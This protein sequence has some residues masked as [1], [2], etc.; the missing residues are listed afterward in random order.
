MDKE[1]LEGK[2]KGF[3]DMISRVASSCKGNETT[4]KALLIEP[5]LQ[6]IGIPTMNPTY[7]HRENATI[8]NERCDYA[9]LREEGN[10]PII[11]I[12]AKAIDNRLTSEKELNQLDRYFRDKNA[13]LGALTNGRVW[14][15]YKA[16]SGQRINALDREPVIEFNCEDLSTIPWDFLEGLHF[17]KLDPENIERLAYQ[18]LLKKKLSSWIS[19]VKKNP[20]ENFVQLVVEESGLDKKELSQFVEIEEIKSSI[21]KL[22]NRDSQFKEEITTPKPEIKPKGTFTDGSFSEPKFLQSTRGGYK[23]WISKKDIGE[24]NLRS[25]YFYGLK[26]LCQNHKSGELE[27]LEIATKKF[28]R[29]INSEMVSN[30]KYWTSFY[31]N[32]EKTYFIYFHMGLLDCVRNLENFTSITVLHDG[33]MAQYGKDLRIEKLKP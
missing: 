2:L 20:S 32:G 11:L 18:E 14:K 31:K 1:G 28:S 7:F 29:V 16:L 9:I 17:D 25:G 4:T 21:K 6:I 19:K 22:L 23:L 3:P 15:W 30:P 24:T 5:F 26:W 13:I 10:D 8:S 27:W 33:K 12:E